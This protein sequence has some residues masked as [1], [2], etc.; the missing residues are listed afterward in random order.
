M[1]KNIKST[2]KEKVPQRITHNSDIDQ[3]L[4]HNES[5]SVID[6]NNFPIVNE[7]ESVVNNSELETVSPHIVSSADSALCAVV[8][9]PEPEPTVNKEETIEE[10]TD[11]V[12]DWLWGSEEKKTVLGLLRGRKMKKELKEHLKDKDVK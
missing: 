7:S 6:V 3:I 9:E 8:S 1:K 4:Q 11:K 5:K 12:M 10:K 2:K